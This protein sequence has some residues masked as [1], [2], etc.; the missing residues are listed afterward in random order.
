MTNEEAIQAMQFYKEKLYNGIFK[1]KIGSFD[2][3]ISAL[4]KQIPKKPIDEFSAHAI[5]DNDGNYLEQLD[6]TTFKCPI[7]NRILA[8]GEIS[9]TD[10]VEIHYCDN[11]GQALDWSETK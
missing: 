2:T 1:E 11:C 7:C 4:E 3:A 6:T 8:S 10:C 5:Y 9:I